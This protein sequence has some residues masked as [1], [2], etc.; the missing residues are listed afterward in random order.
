MSGIEARISFH[1]QK[2]VVFEA[3]ARPRTQSE[4]PKDHLVLARAYVAE[5]RNHFKTRTSNGQPPGNLLGGPNKP[6]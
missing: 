5:N 3:L 1:L 2:G 4:Q 6:H